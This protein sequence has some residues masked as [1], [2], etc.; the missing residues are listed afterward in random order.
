MRIVLQSAEEA[1]AVLRKE[2]RSAS[3]NDR[4]LT[5]QRRQALVGLDAFDELEDALRNG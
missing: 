1:L 4:M 2:G 3:L 5:W